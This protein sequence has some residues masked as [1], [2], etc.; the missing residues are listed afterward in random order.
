MPAAF[1]LLDTRDAAQRSL[2]S[3]AT[4]KVPNPRISPDGRRLA[5]DAMQPGRPPEVAIAPL[6][7]STPVQEPEWIVIREP[8]SHPFWSRDGRVLYFLA[9]F[10][11]IDIRSRV[12]ARGFDPSTGQI[13]SDTSE[14][15]TLGEMIVPAMV[16]GTAPIVAPGQIIFVLGDFRGDVWIRDV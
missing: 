16:T 14:V 7:H 3:S 1:L 13:A 12:L 15:L 2:L 5:S 4:R 9:T 11:N 8:A 6:G 10:P